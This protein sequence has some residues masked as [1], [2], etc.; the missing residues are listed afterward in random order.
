MKKT[1]RPVHSQPPLPSRQ[2]R[3]RRRQPGRRVGLLPRLVLLV[4]ARHQSLLVALVVC[5][6]TALAEGSCP[7][8][9]F[10]YPCTCSATFIGN[11]VM[12]SLVDEEH[13]ILPLQ[14]LRDYNVSRLFLS[15]VTSSLKAGIFMGLKVGTFKVADSRFKVEEDRQDAWPAQRGR[16][17]RIQNLQFMRCYV[18]AGP[19]FFGALD[20]LEALSIMNSTVVRFGREWIGSLVNLT[21]L[22]VEAVTFQELGADAL[23]DLHRL[24]T[25]VWA[26]NG[27]S[28]VTRQF[29][30]R[31]AAYLVSIDLR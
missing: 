31:R 7:S 9:E 6:L 4:F 13:L 1:G 16:W 3:G 11:Y 28:F 24:S 23:A 20:R 29:F 25:L 15:N 26:S 10:V 5:A 22:V 30:P 8:G 2:A 27:A 18:D 12:C 21:H 17:T 14:Y 19:R